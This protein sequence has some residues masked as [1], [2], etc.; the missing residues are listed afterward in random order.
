MTGITISYATNLVLAD[1]F[2]IVL[3]ATF[4]TVLADKY[5]TKNRV[6]VKLEEARS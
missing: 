3:I 5:S 2:V 1:E 4:L 6:I